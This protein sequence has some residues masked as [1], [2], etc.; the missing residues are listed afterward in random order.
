MSVHATCYDIINELRYFRKVSI[1]GETKDFLGFSQLI[2]KLKEL[3]YSIPQEFEFS[4]Y[5]PYINILKNDKFYYNH[6][7]NTK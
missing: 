7:L 6:I 3:E 4:K 1:T 2:K 5:L